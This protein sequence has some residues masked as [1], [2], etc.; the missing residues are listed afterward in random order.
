MYDVSVP[1]ALVDLIPVLLYLAAA[2][3]LQRD[4]YNKMGRG[5]F[6]LFAAGTIFVFV[7]GLFQAAWKLLYAAGISD[8]RALNTFFLPAQSLGFLL[9]GVA[10]V[11]MLA[12]RRKTR[13]EKV[14]SLGATSAVPAV[15]SG[16][17]VFL[18]MM[19]IGLGAVCGGLA[20]LSFRM[21]RKAAAVFF[22]LTFIFSMGMGYLAG[23]D[24]TLAWVNWAEE[25]VNI[26]SQLMLL[27][28]TL[29]LHR[30]GLEGYQI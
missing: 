29:I 7:A 2:V 18:G 30:N 15:F 8:F 24:L 5:C 4:L 19:V 25:G 11:L 27:T 3:I 17:M 10:I 21:K 23:Q 13:D 14:L 9:A 12:A 20:V 16:S 28:G 6:A 26:V 1:M 22:I